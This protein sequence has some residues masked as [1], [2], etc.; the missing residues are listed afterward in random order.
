MSPP[1]LRCLGCGQIHADA[2]QVELPDGR[3]VGS[4]SEAY[5]RYTEAAWVLATLPDKHRDKSR[6]TKFKYLQDIE[7]RRGRQARVEL[8]EEMLRVYY[9]LKRT[10][11]P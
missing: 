4:H 9:H 2:R 5:R 3:Q 6:M 10:S 8:R 1:D 11:K 7:L